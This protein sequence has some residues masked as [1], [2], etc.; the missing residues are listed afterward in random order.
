M[1]LVTLLGTLKNRDIRLKLDDGEKIKII[2]QRDRLDQALLDELTRQKSA[3]I[4]WLK[5]E[6]SLS[7]PPIVAEPREKGEAPA[8][9]G[10]Q[11]LWF[12]AQMEGAGGAYHISG[13]VRLKGNLDRVALRHAL[14]RIVARH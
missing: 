2:G 14:D 12:L 13:G 8:S 9:Y 5:E 1:S 7:R 4:E 11:R 6:R 3:I 10:Q